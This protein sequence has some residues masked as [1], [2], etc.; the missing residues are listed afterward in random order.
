MVLLK[1]SNCPCG[2]T[3]IAA[4]NSF[5]G[6]TV[7]IALISTSLSLMVSLTT[8]MSFDLAFSF[9][10]PVPLK[11]RH[12]TRIR[13]NSSFVFIEIGFKLV[14]CLKVKSH[15]LPSPSLRGLVFTAHEAGLRTISGSVLKVS[16][17]A[18]DYADNVADIQPFPW[19]SQIF[20]C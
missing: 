11:P 16:V 3:E 15:Q 20:Q 13:H 12:N 19:D 17:N 18:P 7:L 5:I 9:S 4:G 8:A 14:L 10:W 6:V 2:T 1:S